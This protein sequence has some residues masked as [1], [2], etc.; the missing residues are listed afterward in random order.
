MGGNRQLSSQDYINI[1]LVHKT[2]I[3]SEYY[4]AFNAWFITYRTAYQC[5]K[6]R[7]I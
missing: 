4:V 1:T 7:C 6:Y 2:D 3:L 5:S